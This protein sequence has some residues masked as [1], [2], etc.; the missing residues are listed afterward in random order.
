ML[1]VKGGEGAKERGV[2]RLLSREKG[3]KPSK[4]K[5]C[6]KGA[7]S[8]ESEFLPKGGEE[9][10]RR[11]LQTQKNRP[12]KYHSEPKQSSTRESGGVSTCKNVKKTLESP[13]LMGKKETA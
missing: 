1:L 13:A 12:K 6:V 11:V 8:K 7:R 5:G 3:K 10:R 4:G 2:L 9:K